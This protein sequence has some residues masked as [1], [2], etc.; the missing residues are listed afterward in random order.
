MVA[1]LVIIKFIM[2]HPV[3][4][5][6]ILI[7]LSFLA[8]LLWPL[9]LL[10]PKF[11][12][13]L[14]ILFDVFLSV[15]AITTLM[16]FD[17]YQS[18]ITFSSLN[19]LNQV[20]TISDSIFALLKPVYVFFFSDFILLIFL[21]FQGTFTL[22]KLNYLLIPLVLVISTGL[23]QSTQTLNELNKYNEVG[24]IGYQLSQGASTLSRQFEKPQLISAK[25]LHKDKQKS[26][27]K[28]QNAA[29]NAPLIM[30]QLESFQ[31]FVI[32]LRINDQEVTPNLQKLLD[33]TY[34]FPNVYSQVGK[35]NTSDAE[36]IVN[37]SLYAMGNISMST[38][39]K[40][41]HVP[42]LP[43][44]LN[45]AGYHTAT[46]HTNA[47]SFWNRH[48]L[49]RALGFAEYYDKKFFGTNDIISYGSSDEIL[50][51][52]S[53]EKMS[54]FHQKYGRFY[55]H[56]IAM[57]SHFPFDLP[58]GKLPTTLELPA[59]IKG[60]FVGNYLQSIHYADYAFGQFIQQLK[61]N[62]LY[63]QSLLVVYGDHF[64]LQIRSNQDKQIV[65][66]LFP[67]GYHKVLDHL[68]VP[69]FIKVPG[70]NQG[71]TI[72]T[73]GGLVDIY[74]TVANLLGLN[75]SKEVVFGR[76]LLNTKN[77]LIG[78]RFYAPTGTFINQDYVFTPGLKR[79]E[80]TVTNHKNKSSQEANATALAQ[81]EEILNDM[82]LSD[83]YIRS[84]K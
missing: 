19:E 70:I 48:D 36:F 79:Y 11:S 34:Y 62:G 21:R 50:Y 63:D 16:Y 30:V 2:I 73:V 4:F 75:L 83:Q 74:P 17:F 29:D 72:E 40:G 7:E 41:K 55:S 67:K 6:S 1:K 49:Y 76:D 8:V 47:V 64:G 20:S 44:V 25:T 37:T 22:N 38:E 10:P 35:G 78:I 53:N 23:Y 28:L 3:H 69:L 39:V 66:T 9:T 18:I 68:N 27:P 80:G 61:E 33:E 82:K 56:I 14:F 52:K 12:I 65:N 13:N 51:K 58:E 32:G 46:F 42:S 43:R 57:S 84:L 81:L 71:Q 60:T 54:E 24:L 77:N 31:D 15:I 5:T 45:T 26:I 59:H